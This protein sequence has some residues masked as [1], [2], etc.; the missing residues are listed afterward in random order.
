MRQAWIPLVWVVLAG[1]LVSCAAPP[2]EEA[3]MAEPEP[4][5]A[6][7]LARA[8]IEHDDLALAA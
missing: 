3:V 5:L 4:I 2:P 6:E 8:A 1:F 7:P